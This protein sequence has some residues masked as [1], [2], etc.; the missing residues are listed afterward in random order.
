[1][2]APIAPHTAEELWEVLGQQYSVHQQSWP[3]WNEKL[4][5]EDVIEIPVQ[6]NGKLRD[7]VEVP[8]T[9]DEET[10]RSTVLARPKIAEELKGKQ[11][12]KFIYSPGRLVN[13]VVK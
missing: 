6:V 2:L 9:A 13:L 7:R 11:L 8:A 4:A 1:M 3:Q 10:V 5:A 12:V